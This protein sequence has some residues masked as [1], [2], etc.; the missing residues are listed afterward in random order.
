MELTG[1]GSFGHIGSGSGGYGD[2][3]SRG[4]GFG[5]RGYGSGGDGYDGY[6]GYGYGVACES[7]YDVAISAGVLQAR[8][9]LAEPNQELRRHLIQLLGPDKFFRGL[10]AVVVHADID[11]CGNP[12]RLI[13]VP[14]RDAAKGYLQA[15][16]VID[17][18]SGADYYL[19]VPPDVSTCQEAVAN[20][21]GL[22]AEDYQPERES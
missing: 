2:F 14:L 1:Y 4:S 6:D 5:S 11:G 9:V 20:T 7:Y 22:S 12:R 18:T 13:R 3:G 16:H 21:F 8:H 10:E 15:V 17:P 19:G